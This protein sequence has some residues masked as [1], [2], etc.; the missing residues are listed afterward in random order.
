MIN[1]HPTEAVL[2]EFVAGT[3]PASVAI[4]VASHVD[5]CEQCQSLVGKLTEQAAMSA[6]DT[7][8]G[9]GFDQTND[10]IEM[11]ALSFDSEQPEWDISLGML[12]KITSQP[13][14]KQP[15]L[16]VTVT[17]IEVSGTRVALPRAMKS[18]SLKEWQGIGKISRAR[19]NLDDDERRMSLLH[20]A[21]GGN[22]PQ[23]THKGYE[24]T[25]LLSGSFDDEMGHYV[26]G[27][28]IWLDSKHTHNP[29]TEEGCV[30]LTVSSDALRFT[31][32]VS[33]LINPLGKLIY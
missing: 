25:L 22:V 27:D 18:L 10:E 28:F 5:M 8:K 1:Y 33:Q 3:L 21:K 24:I 15:E 17:E 19:L 13:V 23:H 12:E 31:Q 11:E 14:E 29:V 26:A 16:P 2:K 9:F 7:T 32:G 4:V 6:F 20:I 30:C